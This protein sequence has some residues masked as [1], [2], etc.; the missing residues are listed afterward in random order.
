VLNCGSETRVVSGSD[1]GLSNFIQ[2]PVG[3][4]AHPRTW[5]A[6][7]LHNLLA[8]REVLEPIKAN[9]LVLSLCA[10]GTYR[11]LAS[12]LTHGA[13]SEVTL[14]LVLDTTL[15]AQGRDL[16]KASLFALLS[17]VMVICV[18]YA[19]PAGAMEKSKI[20]EVPASTARAM[21]PEQKQQAIAYARRNGIR[22]RIVQ[23]K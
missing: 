12:G 6:L 16:V 11:R 20:V 22:W 23:D 21:T 13:A 1:L 10:S 9:G 8:S 15:T 4:R 7:A 2:T 17:A 19:A 5:L 3:Y 18:G 14:M